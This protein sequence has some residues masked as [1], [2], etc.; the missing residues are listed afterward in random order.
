MIQPLLDMAQTLVFT[1]FL[2]RL[3]QPIY[4]REWMPKFTY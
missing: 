2:D 1:L 3:F 4:F